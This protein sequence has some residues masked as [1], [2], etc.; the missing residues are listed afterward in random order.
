MEKSLSLQHEIL[1]LLRGIK[2]LGQEI[3]TNP[4]LDKLSRLCTLE[5]CLYQILWKTYGERKYDEL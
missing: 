3:A 1:L 2:Q 4:S 5:D